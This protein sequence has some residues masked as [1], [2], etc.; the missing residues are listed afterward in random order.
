MSR[1]GSETYLV[2]EDTSLKGGTVGQNT[3]SRQPTQS[4]TCKMSADADQGRLPV[5]RFEARFKR[6]PPPAVPQGITRRTPIRTHGATP[7]NL[8]ERPYRF[9]VSSRTCS[10]EEPDG[11][12]SVHRNRPI[13]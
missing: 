4:E 1:R 10:E 2:A 11:V 5:F 12:S 8:Q 9:R 6:K 13:P 3:L 7:L